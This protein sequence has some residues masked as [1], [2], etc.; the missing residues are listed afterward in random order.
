MFPMHSAGA[1]GPAGVPD[2]QTLLGDPEARRLM[3]NI[4]STI[5]PTELAT[6][7]GMRQEQVSPAQPVI[8]TMMLHTHTHTHTH[9]RVRAHT[10]VR[11]HIH[12]VTRHYHHKYGLN[13]VIEF[14]REDLVH[15]SELHGVFG[16]YMNC[17]LEYVR[18]DLVHLSELH[19]VFGTY[20]KWWLQ[21]KDRKSW[22]IAIH[23]LK[24]TNNRC[25]TGAVR[26]AVH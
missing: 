2:M 25:R 23:K 18:E 4:M 20:I 26:A 10:R 9:A 13:V 19:G 21:C 3:R 1:A 6:M 15:L 11:T 8:I 22:T 24:Q 7:T 14:V 17:W 12:L 5:N 16:T